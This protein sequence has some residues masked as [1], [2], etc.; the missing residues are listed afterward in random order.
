M[1]AA[2]DCVA[3]LTDK[4]A[5]A[6]CA[7]AEQLW[8]ESRTSEYWYPYFDEF[9]ALLRHKNSLVRNRAIAILAANARWDSEHKF[10]TLLLCGY[11][12]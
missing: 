11:G 5:A 4:D 9:A 6:T 7:Y 8:E 10:E 12:H 2:S 1:M 3:R